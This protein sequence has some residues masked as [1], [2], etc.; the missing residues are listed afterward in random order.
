MWWVQ[1]NAG[2]NNKTLVEMLFSYIYIFIKS[3]IPSF[4]HPSFSHIHSALLHT[5]PPFTITANDHDF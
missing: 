1:H 5:M 3:L 4:H 2:R